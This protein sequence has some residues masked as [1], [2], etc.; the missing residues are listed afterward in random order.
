MNDLIIYIY[1]KKKEK[2][3]YLNKL[4]KIIFL[5]NTIIKRIINE[6]QAK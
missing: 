5:E 3:K 6:Q 1:N 4:K 2:K